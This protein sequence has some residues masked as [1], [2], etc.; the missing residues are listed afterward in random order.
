MRIL[1]FAG[2]ALATFAAAP[3]TTKAQTYRPWCAPNTFGG[4]N[5]AFDSREQCMASI[6]GMGVCRENPERPTAATPAA[7]PAGP[8]TPA[9][10]PSG[11]DFGADPD[12]RVRNTLTRDSMNATPPAVHPDPAAPPPPPGTP[13]KGPDGKVLGADPDAKVRN[14]IQ[15]EAPGA[16]GFIGAFGPT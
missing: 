5:C 14:N 8:A 1:F 3:Q 10:A 4:V 13:V 9:F 12:A 16:D 11:K 2:C 6:N 7:A 15:R